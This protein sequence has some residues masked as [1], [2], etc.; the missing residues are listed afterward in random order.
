MFDATVELEDV[1]AA[2]ATLGYL[3]RAARRRRDAGRI[4]GDDP[5]AW[6]RPRTSPVQP[7]R[8]LRRAD[9]H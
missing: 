1:Q 8:P 5:A 4:A 7:W 2:E 6:R 3:V 9:R